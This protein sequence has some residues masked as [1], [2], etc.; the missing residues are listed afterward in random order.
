MLYS[1]LACIHFILIHIQILWGGGKLGEHIGGEA[2]L[3]NMSFW[4]NYENVSLCWMEEVFTWT[5]WI[6]NDVL[7]FNNLYN[8]F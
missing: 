8:G 5:I 6:N 3:I 1:L 2:R 7:K 4:T